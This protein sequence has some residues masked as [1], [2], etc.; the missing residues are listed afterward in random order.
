MT[1]HRTEPLRDADGN[2]VLNLEG[3]TT[4]RY[5]TIYDAA[6]RL[7]DD[8]A[9]EQGHERTPSIRPTSH[10]F[11]IPVLCHQPHMKPAAVCRLCVV[12]LY[13]KRSGERSRERKL[14]PA[15]QHQVSDGMEVF[16]IKAAGPDGERMRRAMRVLTEL[17]TADHLDPNPNAGDDLGLL[18]E[19]KHT[20]EGYGIQDSRFK[21]D[22]FGHRPPPTDASVVDDSSV[23]F[24]VDHRSCILCD[25]C[26][27]ACNDVKHNFVIGRTGKGTSL[28][29]GSTCTFPWERQPVFSAA[30]AWF[31]AQLMPLRSSRW[32]ELT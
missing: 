3:G 6:A 23:V 25:R 29:S 8:E 2:I 5:I 1:V 12:Q 26:S 30:S 16:R 24:T 22:V 18:N 27:R 17:L 21:A 13:R 7:Y 10:R 19:L 14:L 28:A 11:P 32:P 4:P 15:C 31:H 9:R 20:A